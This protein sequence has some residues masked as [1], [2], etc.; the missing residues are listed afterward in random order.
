[1][2]VVLLSLGLLLI[3]WVLVCLIGHGYANSVDHVAYLLHRHAEKMRGIHDRR[4]AI[5]SERWVKCLENCVVDVL[6]GIRY[7]K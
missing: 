3:T 2:S 7:D 4:R 6:E 5:V 1:M